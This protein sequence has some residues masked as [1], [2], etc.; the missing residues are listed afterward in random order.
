QQMIE[1][2]YERLGDDRQ[3][4]PKEIEISIAEGKA[5]LNGSVRS[6]DLKDKAAQIAMTVPGVK[7]VDNRLEIHE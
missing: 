6:Q 2:I 3:L 1:T 7:T 5:I 4:D